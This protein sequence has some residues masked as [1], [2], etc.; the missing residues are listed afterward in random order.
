MAPNVSE[1][2]AFTLVTPV[3][4]Q[5][6]LLCV[7]FFQVTQLAEGWHVWKTVSMGIG[8]ELALRIA[9][10]GIISCHKYQGR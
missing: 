5:K 4:K 7:G 3:S 9:A 8:A 2:R 1:G 10:P 6:V